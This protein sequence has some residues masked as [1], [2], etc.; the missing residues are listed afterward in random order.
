MTVVSTMYTGNQ[1]PAHLPLP[2]GETPE[3]KRQILRDL[4]FS[5]FKRPSFV[6]HTCPAQQSQ[7]N[8]EPHTLVT[9]NN[10]I[11]YTP[12]V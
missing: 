1:G 6:L 12:S 8:L 9:V 10:A 5:L 7:C 11:T 2:T 4:V 3:A